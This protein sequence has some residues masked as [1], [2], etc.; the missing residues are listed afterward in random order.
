MEIIEYELY[1]LKIS[2]IV[3][4]KEIF[5]TIVLIHVATNV[6]SGFSNRLIAIHALRAASAKVLSDINSFLLE[7]EFHAFIVESM[8]ISND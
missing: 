5:I 2:L 8:F 4:G 3:R 7:Q 6:S 1:S